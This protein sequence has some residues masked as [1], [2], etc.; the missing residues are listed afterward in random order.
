VFQ[1]PRGENRSL[2]DR[3]GALV[4]D[5]QPTGLAVGQLHLV[6]RVDL[7]GLVRPLGSMLGLAAA[8]TAGGRG[9]QGGLGEGP[10]D[11][12]LGRQGPAG[13]SL[14]QDDPDDP[15]A[16]TRVLASH[17]R[18]GLD[19]VG[20][21]LAR[22]VDAGSEVIR[23]DAGGPG[24]PEAADQLPDRLGVQPQVGGDGLGPMSEGGPLE[25][26]SS[27]RNGDGST[28]LGPPRR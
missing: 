13:M 15:G 26:D 16:P 8:A 10:L 12:P 2:Q 20:V 9:I 21:G 3:P 22:L 7:P 5:A 14:G 6:G 28:H 18:G 19:Q 11:C 4:D 17:R 25:D 23:R 24:A 27:L 1:H